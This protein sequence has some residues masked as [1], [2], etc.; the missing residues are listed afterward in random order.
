MAVSSTVSRKKKQTFRER[1]ASL[2]YH[3]AAKLLGDNGVKLL[4]T[5]AQQFAI[6]PEQDVYLG[7][8]LLRVRIHDPDEDD[9]QAVVLITQTTGKSKELTLCCDHCEVPCEHMG[10][11]LDVLLNERMYFGLTAPPD[12]SVPMEL[13]TLEELEQRALEERRQRAQ[14][15]RMSLRT[16]D[17]STPWCDYVL[18]SHASGKSYRVSL[19]GP[20]DHD[21]Y[22]SCPDF[23]TNQLGTCK[24]IM[25]AREKI[26]KRFKNSELNKKH[27]PNQITLSLDS[28][29]TTSLRFTIPSDVQDDVRNVSKQVLKKPCLDALSAMAFL[30]K[31]QKAGHEVLVYP[32]A[33]EWIERELL[34][35]KLEQA[36]E[37]IRQCP[38][39]HPLRKTL[40]KADLLP[41]QM[42]GIAFAV[43]AGRA[44]L[45]DDMGLGKTIQ[46]IGTAELLAQLIGIRRVLV[47]CP[48]SVK[49][50]WQHEIHRFC[51]R[52]AQVIIGRPEERREAYNN[53][54]FF[55]ICNYEQ[56]LR[57]LDAVER[58][59]WDLIILD[60][61]QRIK[62]WES[63]TSQVI[64]S[65]RSRFALVLSGTPLENRLDE[66]Y[67]VTR[68]VDDRRLGPAYKFFHKHRVVDDNG[69]V[70]GYRNLDE[71]REELKPILLRRTRKEVMQQLPD[72]TDTIVRIRPTAEQMDLHSGHMR[73]VSSI[74]RKR[75]LTEMDLLRLQKAL[76]MCR[77][78][79]DATILVD[80]EGKNYSSKL[81]RL[82]ELLTELNEQENRKIVLFSEWR[83]MLDLIEPILKELKMDFVRLD[84]NVPQKHR[85][86]LVRR[87]QEEPECRVILMTNAGSTGL[88]LQSANTVINVDLPWNPAVLEQRIARAH[89]MGQKNPVHVYLLVTE[90]TLEEKL[91]DTLSAKQDLASAAIDMESDVDEVAMVSGIE[92]LRRR[93]EKMF[94]PTEDAPTD[95][96]LQ[97]R[98]EEETR[99]IA[100]K[101]EKVAA[102]GGQLIGAAFEMVA[103]LISTQGSPAPDPEMVNRLRQG[104]NDSVER[105]ESGRP[106]LRITLPDDNSL[107]QFAQ[108][109]AQLLITK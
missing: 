26:G 64:R 44:V 20:D 21:A 74:T 22:C 96:S 91:L 30:Q 10:A 2:T 39:Q 81:D 53:D 75:Y 31:L 107:Q 104:L 9:F 68:F 47:V 16:T 85:P 103:G 101:R 69:K 7:G 102:A 14:N 36:T 65:L 106:Q 28:G 108:T 77:M 98:V 35:S 6:D 1:L 37:E 29:T 48:A 61:G 105:D 99:V 83:K 34:R 79:A 49:S 27:E 38:A 12:E 76:M 88:N 33:E 3:Q 23:R 43:G 67:T 40:L 84:G 57:D 13:L 60:E 66:L 58:V 90:D 97:D 100:E 4:R 11:A 73:T 62:N 93:L 94:G 41:Y 51:D 71:L 56:I 87:F 54:T 45:A 92:E 18:T 63:K 42:D 19:L 52:S 82:K 55:T 25:H 32:D 59:D 89:R 78:S 5:G 17:P 8:D 70:L 86:A 80:K 24:H 50:Q 46:G 95:M 72:R 109:L 15:E